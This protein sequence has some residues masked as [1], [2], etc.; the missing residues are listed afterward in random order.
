MRQRRQFLNDEDRS[1]IR[2]DIYANSKYRA[3][4][5]GKLF[6]TKFVEMY[7]Y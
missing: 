6:F 2:S 3:D 4:K 5:D 1:R 7:Q